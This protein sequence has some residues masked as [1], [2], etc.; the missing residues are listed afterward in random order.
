MPWKG[1]TT[2]VEKLTSSVAAAFDVLKTLLMNPQHN[3]PSHPQYSQPQPCNSNYHFEH[4]QAMQSNR[5]VV[6]NGMFR[7]PFSYIHS[8]LQENIDIDDTKK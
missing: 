7:D 4:M 3:Y 8:L 5:A 1:L 2:N 6:N